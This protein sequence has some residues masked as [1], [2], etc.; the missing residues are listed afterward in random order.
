MARAIDPRVYAQ[1]TQELGNLY[2]QLQK[3]NTARK[4]SKDVGDW[5]GYSQLT[6]QLKAAN[7]QARALQRT[8][9]DLGRSGS[10]GLLKTADAL[11]QL[12]NV[13]QSGR[14]GFIPPLQHLFGHAQNFA[15]GTSPFTT[16]AAAAQ[17]ASRVAAQEASAAAARHTAAQT[18]HQ[19]A[20]RAA[21]AAASAPHPHTAAQAAAVQATQQAAARTFAQQTSAG[22]AS[23]A[24]QG[25]ANA[26]AANAT[27]ALAASTPAFEAIAAAAGPVGIA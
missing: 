27:Q 23:Q 12:W 4:A 6:E 3:L 11:R 17:Q 16:Q 18:A 8:L 14:H 20:A 22:V 24:A 5:Q 13:F 26:A 10:S 15:Q 21:Q 2:A 1:L 7:E 9:D 25:T 19:A